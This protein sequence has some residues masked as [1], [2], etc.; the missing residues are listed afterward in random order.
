MESTYQTPHGIMNC[1][2]NYLIFRVSTNSINR[3]SA[4]EIMRYA[5]NHY[6]KRRFVFISSRQ[7][8]SNVDP[9][10][11][12]TIDPRLMVGIAIVSED[13]AVRNEAVEEQNFYKGS[14]SFFQTED[15]AADWANTVVKTVSQ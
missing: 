15:E 4:K 5:Y 14:F 13:Y 7:F 1:F 11:Y 8:V 9:E 12:E 10:A 2:S 3:Q 6:K